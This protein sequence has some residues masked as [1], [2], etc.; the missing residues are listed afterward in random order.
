MWQNCRN[1][2]QIQLVPS[3]NL[4]NP[5]KE[6]EKETTT[7]NGV[8]WH[9]CQKCFGGK[10]SWNKTYTTSEH[11][12]SAGKGYKN[13]KEENPPTPG[14]SKA[15]PNIV[16]ANLAST[17]AETAGTDDNS[18]LFFCLRLNLI[19]MLVFSPL[20][21]FSFIQAIASYISSLFY[22]ST[23]YCYRRSS[24]ALFSP[25]LTFFSAR[26]GALYNS[27]MVYH[28]FIVA[29]LLG[30]Y[31][32]PSPSWRPR[33]QK[34]SPQ[35]TKS[36]KPKTPPAPNYHR[37]R[38]FFFIYILFTSSHVYAVFRDELPIK[39]LCTM[40]MVLLCSSCIMSLHNNKENRAIN[41]LL[42]SSP[43]GPITDVSLV[44][45]SFQTTSCNTKKLAMLSPWQT[46]NE[47]SSTIMDYVPGSKAICIDTGAS[48]CIS[49][50]KRDFLTIHP[51]TNLVL[52]L[53]LL[54]KVVTLFTDNE[55]NKI[56]LYVS[57][58]LYVPNI[59]ICLLCPQQ[60]AKQTNNP[61]VWRSIWYL[62][63]DGFVQ[64]VPYNRR[65]G[66]PLI[67]V[68]A[69]MSN[70][71]STTCPNPHTA[72][73]LS[74]AISDDLTST[75]LSKSQR[76]LLHIHERMAHLNFDEIQNLARLGYFL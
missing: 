57:D 53:A 31:W 18:G 39:S 19:A 3:R 15:S 71:S 9:Y 46:T 48:A 69:P 76:K 52:D 74:T 51:T 27:V 13:G 14:V 36:T 59:P 49:N 1:H 11:I 63:Y 42:H 66:L 62:T 20:L 12:K 50:D 75:N 44:P 8:T 2:L 17:T 70:A 43:C 28:W 73:Y 41:K 54:L 5:P 56:K 64:T 34:S 35:P 61:Q 4:L 45:D 55:G 16:V 68:N 24:P 10:G 47:K 30:L 67:F 72:A 40:P 23:H 32:D 33:K 29:Q 26:Y 25:S 65:N 7:L 6:G 58:A 22:T 60:V 21:S 37:L 38:L